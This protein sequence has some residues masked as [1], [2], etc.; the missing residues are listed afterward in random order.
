VLFGTGAVLLYLLPT[1]AVPLVAL[2]TSWWLARERFIRGPWLY[3]LA[4]HLVVALVATVPFGHVA[5]GTLGLLALAGAAFAAAQAWRRTLPDEAAVNRAGQPDRYLLHL[6]YLLLFGSLATHLWL[7][8]LIQSFDR[9]VLTVLLMLEVVAVFS[10][11]LLLRRQDLR[12][13]ALAGMLGCLVRLVFFDLSR[14]GTITRAIVFIFMGLLLL[15]MNALY[16]RFK[17]R[18]APEEEEAPTEPEAE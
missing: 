14:S 16:A 4:L 3:L 8:L 10:T 11:S 9:S 18:F 15:G 2:R 13:V 6:S 1:L 17:A 7:L 12:Y 5:Y